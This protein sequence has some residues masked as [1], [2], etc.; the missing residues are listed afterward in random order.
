MKK[1]TKI[2]PLPT[3]KTDGTLWETTSGQL[4]HTHVSGEYKAKYK[5]FYLYFTTDEEIATGDWILFS[6]VIMIVKSFD[7]RVVH[8]GE[9]NSFMKGDCKKII[10]TTDPE[11]NK[12]WIEDLDPEKKSTHTQIVTHVGVA[13]PSQAFVERYCKVGGIDE[14]DVEYELSGIEKDELDMLTPY[15]YWEL[16]V[17]SNNEIT[18]H[19]IKDSWNE[20]EICLHMQYYMEYCLQKGYVSPQKWLKELKPF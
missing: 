10:A 13:K 2:I 11:L 20:E 4:I 3:D 7:D 6:D 18:I 8:D 17:N 9:G 5:P 19:S 1:R 16:K 15:R 14:V 12:G